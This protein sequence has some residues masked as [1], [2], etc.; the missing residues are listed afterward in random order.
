MLKYCFETHFVKE[1]AS[2]RPGCNPVEVNVDTSQMNLALG[3][4]RQGQQ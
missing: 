3:C 2:F 1:T 4:P